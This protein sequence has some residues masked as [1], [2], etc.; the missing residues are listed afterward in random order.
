LI[1][2]HL[3]TGS[4]IHEFSKMGSFKLTSQQSVPVTVSTKLHNFG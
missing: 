3:V 1:S 2:L 4:L